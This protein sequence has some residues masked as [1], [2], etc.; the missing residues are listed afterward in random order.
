MSKLDPPKL[1]NITKNIEAWLKAN[2]AKAI[3]Q[4]PTENERFKFRKITKITRVWKSKD[5]WVVD[6]F[7]EYSFPNQK[8]KTFTFQVNS[9]GEVL[10]FDL[11]EQPTRIVSI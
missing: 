8:T 10:G 4:S 7:V 6:A 9:T 5:C 2:F 3:A 1:E 11:N